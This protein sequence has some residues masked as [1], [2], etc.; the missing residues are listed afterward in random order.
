MIT[1]KIE[2]KIKVIQFQK[3]PHDIR[4]VNGVLEVE[5]LYDVDKQYKDIQDNLSIFYT[6][7]KLIEEKK[8]IT[9]AKNN[10]ELIKNFLGKSQRPK[11][12]NELI[13]GRGKKISSST[14]SI[15]FLIPEPRV[16][17]SASSKNEASDTAEFVFPKVVSTSKL[18]KSIT[19]K[20]DN[21]SSDKTFYFYVVDSTNRVIQVEEITIKY[22]DI[23]DAR[24]T[25]VK[26]PKINFKANSGENFSF[27]E[28]SSTDN[29]LGYAVF[30]KTVSPRTN[31]VDQFFYP[32]LS[33]KY[34]VNGKDIL[35]L[36]SDKHLT[37]YYRFLSYDEN[38]N[39]SNEFSGCVVRPDEKSVIKNFSSIW[40]KNVKNY[41]EVN[42]ENIPNECVCFSVYCHEFRSGKFVER[43]VKEGILKTK[44]RYTIEDTKISDGVIQYY[45]V[46]FDLL[47]GLTDFVMSKQEKCLIG[48][49]GL[50]S[51]TL[52]ESRLVDNGSSYDVAFK[53]KL[54]VEK[55]VQEKL[56]EILKSKGDATIYLSEL[57]K[58]KDNFDDLTTFLVFRKNKTSGEVEFLGNFEDEFLDSE[59]SAKTGSS[60]LKAGN[61]YLYEVI[62]CLR[63]TKT[64]LKDNIQQKIDSNTKR[65]YLQDI[66]KYEHPSVDLDGSIST[67]ESRLRGNPFEEFYFGRI[68]V[69]ESFEIT[70]PNDNFFLTN[71]LFK[72]LTTNK[73]ILSF[74][75]KGLPVGVDFVEVFDIIESN[76]T[77]IGS[78][79]PVVGKTRYKI[80][81][82]YNC[83][84]IYLRA[85]K[86]DGSVS[87]TIATAISEG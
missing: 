14:K 73:K 44:E 17:K 21:Y 82:P 87:E 6:N 53:P 33:R 8:E 10:E 34:L 38:L 83:E 56:K 28:V 1:A 68:G 3:T 18:S 26:P 42:I 15:N 81:V 12:N 27:F 5:Y 55:S 70:I 52:L 86:L 79:L 58:T 77:R 22:Q 2:K 50:A 74:D 20:T 57:E 80:I 72:S 37:H 84:K 76:E 59:A 32:V 9:S 40:T 4:E 23:L 41:L 63:S 75:M 7:E 60:E 54:I 45:F 66:N 31:I 67:P 16:E 35:F 64:L 48:R 61:S 36:E 30:R 78:I 62:P 43:I 85:V 19:V 11:L 51:V 25:T 69:Y 49:P 71:V 46:K 39:F 24:E 65:R 47:S 13:V 29:S